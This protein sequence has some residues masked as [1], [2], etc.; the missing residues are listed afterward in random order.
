M[1]KMTNKK[2]FIRIL[3]FGILEIF[4]F[5]IS[6]SMFLAVFF[7]CNIIELFNNDSYLYLFE[8]ASLVLG[9]I[10]SAVLEIIIFK[11]CNN[12]NAICMVSLLI[13]QILV[14]YLLYISSQNIIDNTIELLNSD[15]YLKE[16]YSDNNF[17]MYGLS[18]YSWKSEFLKEVDDL[19]SLMRESAKM[20]CIL[21]VGGSAFSIIIT[22]IFK[23]TKANDN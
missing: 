14:F 11:N 9:I 7:K 6:M 22:G 3:C 17:F 19:I 12:K 8:I 10:I 13:I 1:E 18:Y 4:I 21:F 23:M 20:N 5:A 2:L 16:I 15:K